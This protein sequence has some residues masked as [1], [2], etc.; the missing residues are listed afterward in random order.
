MEDMLESE[1]VSIVIIIIIIYSCRNLFVSLV[2]ELVRLLHSST[3]ARAGSL[4]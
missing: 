4:F 3:K 1:K 2:F